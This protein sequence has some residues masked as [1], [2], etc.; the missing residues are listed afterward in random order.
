VPGRHAPATT[1]TRVTGR[2]VPPTHPTPPPHP[3]HRTPAAHPA[4]PTPAAHPTGSTHP[5]HPTG[6]TH[7]THSPRSTHGA[8][9]ARH[10]RS[11]P[12][13]QRGRV[14]A[15]K[16]VAV[17]V[18]RQQVAA[19]LSVSAAIGRVRV[20]V[21]FAIA[22]PRYLPSGYAPVQLAVTPR[23][24]AV[25]GG[26]S[27]L[28]YVA[29]PPGSH[30]STGTSSPAGVQINQASRA[31]AFVGGLPVRTVR[32]GHFAANLHEYRAPRTDI[33]VLT[34][35]DRKGHG[36]AVVTVAQWSHLSVDSLTR[37]AASLQ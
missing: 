29:A 16:P 18:G 22:T 28:T 32:R 13:I 19:G 6:S 10:E 5:T 27:T 15:P 20:R 31:I 4:H 23:V 24:R 26:L 11:R 12:F 9:A 21:P 36:Y 17:Y 30:A 34:W 7:P 8:S 3:T 25:S 33:L 14:A 1:P 37:I 2:P 35:V